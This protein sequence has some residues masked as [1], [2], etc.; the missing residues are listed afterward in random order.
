MDTLFAPGYKGIAQFVRVMV[1][2]QSFDGCVD[3]IDVGQFRL[4]KIYVRQDLSHHRG[5]GD[6]A[7]NDAIP[8]FLFACVAFQP[9]FI[10]DAQRFEFTS[11]HSRIKQDKQCAGC[12]KFG[13]SNTVF[14]KL[15][16]FLIGEC[17]PFFALMSRQDDF[18]HGRIEFIVTCGEVK[19]TT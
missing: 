5:N 4:F 18:C 1:R 13:M 15:F 17:A 19:D 3:G 6:L 9:A 14:N 11:A 2:E 8:H 12:R 7:G 16:L 10:E